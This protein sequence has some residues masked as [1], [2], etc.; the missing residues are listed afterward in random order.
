M[1]F[2]NSNKEF[3]VP[4]RYSGDSV[5]EFRLSRFGKMDAG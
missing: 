2:S 4:H 5:V 1:E 3:P